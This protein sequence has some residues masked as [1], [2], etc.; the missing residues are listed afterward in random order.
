MATVQGQMWRGS[1]FTIN[2]ATG[3]APGTVILRFSG[4]FTARDMY[5]SLTPAT[6]HDLFEPPAP[7]QR[8]VHIFDLSA[9]PYMD[10]VGLGMLVSHFARC[11]GKGVRLVLVGVGPRVLELFKMTRLDNLLPMAATVEEAIGGQC[12]DLSKASADA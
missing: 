3:G 1:N 10:S 4:P 5:N 11:Q 6:L 12:A 2:Q 8:P 7:E 9:V